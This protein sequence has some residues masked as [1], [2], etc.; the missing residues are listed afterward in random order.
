[1][2][3]VPSTMIVGAAS[4]RG[5][6]RIVEAV[7]RVDVVVTE[8]FARLLTGSGTE[9]FGE[10]EGPPSTEMDEE[11][12]SC[13]LRTGESYLNLPRNPATT[14]TGEGLEITIIISKL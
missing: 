2:P 9:I 5:V 1:M 6:E 12:P 3:R 7:A 11:D 8:V 13:A 10:S 4:I 14:K